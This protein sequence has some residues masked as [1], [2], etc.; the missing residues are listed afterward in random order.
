MKKNSNRWI[1]NG[2]YA[3]Q[4]TCI[5]AFVDLKRRE[6]TN[7]F[8]NPTLDNLN[9]SKVSLGRACRDYYEKSQKLCCK[10]CKRPIRKS[11]HLLKN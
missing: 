7:S 3:G 11:S 9:L 8:S 5:Q 10:G 1:K 4:K 6:R 2:S